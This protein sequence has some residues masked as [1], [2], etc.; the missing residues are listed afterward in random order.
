VAELNKIKIK[1]GLPPTKTQV[2]KEVVRKVAN[3]AAEKADVETTVTPAQAAR[4][5]QIHTRNGGNQGYRGHPNQTV[6]NCQGLM[7]LKADGI[8]GPK[9]RARAK[10]LGYPLAP[11]SAQK[12]YDP[13]TK[14]AKV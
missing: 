12:G 6:H 10:E 8:I 4:M 11:R 9:T 3:Q 7:G 2:K 5:L 14:R 1:H 13:V